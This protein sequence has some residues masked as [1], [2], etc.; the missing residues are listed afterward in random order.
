MRS[1]TGAPEDDLHAR[2]RIRNAAVHLF[3]T[4]GFSV[5]LRAIAAEAGVSAALI[6]RHFGSKSGLREA[7]D[8]YVLRLV[9]ESKRA[10][11]ST[12]SPAAVLR[13]L[14][15]VD[16][17][18]HA[19]LYVVESLNAGGV[20]AGTLFEHMVADAEEYLE[21]GVVNG[22]IRPSRDPAARARY[23]TQVGLG[24]MLVQLRLDRARD[25]GPPDVSAF[26][27]EFERVSMLPALELFTDGL[28]TDSRVLETVLA[29][30][31][32][33]PVADG[34]GH[35]GSERSGPAVAPHDV[36]TDPP[37]SPARP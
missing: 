4:Q 10:T 27:H 26:M 3:G 6:V 9:R 14:A 11:V 30:R 18:G 8:D 1:P 35:A 16:Q 21:A 31:A 36:A 22:V 2:A 7:C 34:E 33:A 28:F 19:T 20:L 25:D 23:L 15:E 17:F 37:A 24:G 29:A 12:G 5:G 13:A 32:G